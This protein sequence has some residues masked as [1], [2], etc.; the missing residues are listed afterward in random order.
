MQVLVHPR[1]QMRSTNSSY[2]KNCLRYPQGSIIR[3]TLKVSV[4]VFKQ[5]LN[6]I[7]TTNKSCECV[8]S[9]Q[10]LLIRKKGESKL[11]PKHRFV[12]LLNT[13]KKILRKIYDD[14]TKKASRQN[15]K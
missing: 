4:L 14:K 6:K 12:L 9:S 1:C 13:G 3:K 8:S 15:N 11:I 7:T 5:I 10:V 2:V